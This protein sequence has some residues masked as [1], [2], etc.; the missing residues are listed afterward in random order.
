MGKN[1]QKMGTW[2]CTARHPAGLSAPHPLA[3]SLYYQAPSPIWNLANRAAP[4]AA[5]QPP[6]WHKALQL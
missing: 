3:K 5:R 2:H 4:R 1:A 6:G